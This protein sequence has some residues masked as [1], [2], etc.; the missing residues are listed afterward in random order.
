[1]LNSHNTPRG[2]CARHKCM[3]PSPGGVLCL[4]EGEGHAA[5]RAR[6]AAAAGR[7]VGLAVR[8]VVVPRV[9]RLARQHQQAARGQRQRAALGPARR[10]H[11]Y[12]RPCRAGVQQGCFALLVGV[13][14]LCCARTTYASFPECQILQTMQPDIWIQS[15]ERLYDAHS[16]H[17][18]QCTSTGLSCQQASWREGTAGCTR[19]GSPSPPGLPATARP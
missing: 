17:C 19:A 14:L 15:L 18:C 4:A 13:A 1:M 5:R 11:V 12:Y 2:H 10:A 7:R 9:P 16:I 6:R 8:D 3:Q